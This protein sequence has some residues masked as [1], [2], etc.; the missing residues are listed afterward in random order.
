M[1]INFNPSNMDLPA[2]VTASG[3]MQVSGNLNVVGVLTAGGI[4]GSGESNT[5]SN[6][7]GAAGVFKQKAG[8]DLEFKTLVGS[9]ITINSKTSTIELT[10]SGG[11]STNP[12]GSDTQV[13]FNNNGSFSGSSGFTYNGTGSLSFGSTANDV[14]Q[15]SGTLTVSGSQ[16]LKVFGP[17]SEL[18]SANIISTHTA[19]IGDWEAPISGALVVSADIGTS[20]T[21]N[22]GAAVLYVHSQ[23]N[24]ARIGFKNS[25]TLVSG[26]QKNQV[27]SNTNKGAYVGLFGT[28]LDI[29][30][31]IGDVVIRSDATTEIT[32]SNDGTII[33]NASGDFHK[34]SGSLNISGSQVGLLH[35]VGD[36]TSSNNVS[37]SAFHGD[38]SNLSGIT[39]DPA[40]SNTQ[41]QFNDGGT[42]AGDAG[43][44]FNKTTNTLTPTNLSASSVDIDGGT[45][46]AANITV[47]SGKT[48]DVS[49]GTLTLANDQISGDK[50]QG[51]TIASTTITA[52]ASTTISASTHVSSSNI[53]AESVK[54]DLFKN[55]YFSASIGSN[56][57]VPTNTHNFFNYTVTANLSLTASS[58]VAGASYVFI[59][60]QDAGGT[61]VITFDPSTFKFPSGSA[62][63]MSTGS[64]EVDVVSGISDGIVIYA[65]AAKKFS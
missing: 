9:G 54:S 58:P 56:T 36:V 15:V 14:H 51:G 19:S 18:Y 7:G 2:E 13:Q 22:T 63:S 46:D 41:V 17:Q 33:G 31:E 28:Q 39:G 42:L 65:N 11:G 48:L 52:L 55:T 21:G 32:V 10:A 62:P 24:A 27:T 53:F 26:E 61:N 6:V 12:G 25:S 34:V 60:R 40:G 49:G 20:G 4:S 1:A 5:A 23:K 50:I 8:V 64:Y 59:L 47:G 44:V 30:N 45:I 38:G 3:N 57:N 29:R 43:L 37:A 35:V 16:P